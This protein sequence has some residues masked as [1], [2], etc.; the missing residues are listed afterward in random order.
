MLRC[1]P[2]FEL[3]FFFFCGLF[4]SFFVFAEPEKAHDNAEDENAQE[5][6]RGDVLGQSKGD[7]KNFVNSQG[8]DCA[9]NTKTHPRIV[10]FFA[11]CDETDNA[12]GYNKYP[13]N[14]N[15]SSHNYDFFVKQ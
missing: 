8:H 10:Y 2:S 13:G 15:F 7:F 14:N 9:V 5:N 12:K 11:A 6:P 3:F 4:F 1:V